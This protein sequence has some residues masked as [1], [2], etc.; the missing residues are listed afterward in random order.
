MTKI[1][2]LTHFYPYTARQVW[3]V[4]TDLDH[5]STVTAGLLAFRDL[6]SGAIHQ[7]QHLKVQV[8]LFGKLP[9]QPYEMTVLECDKD[10]MAFRSNESGAGVKSWR[11]SLVVLPQDE[12]SCRIEE[13]I[14]I[15]AGVMTWVFAAW[16]Q[17]MYRK[18]HAPRLRILARGATQ[19]GA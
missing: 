3:D 2:N 4:A 18:R 14:E 11:H 6:P 1:V 5:L 15:D 7:G 17:F 10:K 8:S 19:T 12:G 9:Y 16:A 13:Q